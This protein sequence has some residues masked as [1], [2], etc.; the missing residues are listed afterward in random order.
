MTQVRKGKK[1]AITPVVYKMPKVRYECA[2]LHMLVH[3]LS[4]FSSLAEVLFEYE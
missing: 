2:Q 1:G 3:F 4:N